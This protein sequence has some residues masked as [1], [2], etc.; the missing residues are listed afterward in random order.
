MPQPHH[1]LAPVIWKVVALEDS[2]VGGCDSTHSTDYRN[3]RLNVGK[4]ETSL[5][6]IAMS[7]NDRTKWLHL[8]S[9]FGFY[10]PKFRYQRNVK[11]INPLP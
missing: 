8:Q 2:P 11:R 5:T 3:T 9:H 10:V 1:V 6:C 4:V 7:L